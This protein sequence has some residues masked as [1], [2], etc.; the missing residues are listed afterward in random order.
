MRPL[1]PVR[2]DI[3]SL[4]NLIPLRSSC[5]FRLNS[6]DQCNHPTSS[7]IMV[8]C[9]FQSLVPEEE[10]FNAGIHIDIDHWVVKNLSYYNTQRIRCSYPV[11]SSYT[12]TPRYIYYVFILVALFGRK[13]AW[14]TSA[15][16]GLVM[17]LSSAAA[18]HGVILAAIRQN[19]APAYLFE[20][21]FSEVVQVDGP[22]FVNHMTDELLHNST[23]NETWLPVLPMVR[24]ND[25]NAVLTIVGAAFLVLLPMQIWSSTLRKAGIARMLVGLGSCLLLSGLISALI[26]VEYV[27]FWTFRQYRFCP[28]GA[29]DTLP[30]SNKGPYNYLPNRTHGDQYRWNRVVGEQYVYRNSTIRFPDICLYPCLEFEWLLRD[31]E[32]IYV[33]GQPKTMASSA[34]LWILTAIY[35]MVAS[36]CIAICAFYW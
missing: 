28:P 24:D 2:S 4:A 9:F 21:G 32:D 33:T 22:T 29:H 20:D 14:L 23:T 11:S 16:L 26:Y 17:T 13:S 25:G 31:P 10:M 3:Y 27:I 30:F 35:F 7:L 6:N 19:M 15:A 36:S 1:S 12:Q 5:H 8:D 18:F 34:Q